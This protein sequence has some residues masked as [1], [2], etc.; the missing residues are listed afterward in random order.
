[1]TPRLL[2]WALV[3]GSV[4]PAL[5]HAADDIPLQPVEIRHK[6]NPGDLDYAIVYKLQERVR[7]YLPPEPRV[8]DYRARATFNAVNTLTRTE[9]DNFMPAGWAVAIVGKTVDYTVPTSRGGYF[10]LPD[11]PLAREEG[12]KLMFNTQTQERTMGVTW[13]IRLRDG[14]VLPYRDFAKALEEFEYVRNK[15]RWYE[16]GLA[17]LRTIQYSALRACFVGGDGAILIDGA[18]SG[19]T[20]RGSCWILKFD[21]AKG[22]TDAIIGFTAELESLTLDW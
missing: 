21:A 5:T 16:R 4:V 20:A 15:V 13:S 17:N 11:L 7:A 12:A 18:A 9:R 14:S 19:A 22:S 6:K 8:I 3:A 10:V 1:M 2:A